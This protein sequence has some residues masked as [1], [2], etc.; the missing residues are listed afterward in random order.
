MFMRDVLYNNN[1]ISCLYGVNLADKYLYESRERKERNNMPVLKHYKKM[2]DVTKALKAIRGEVE[3]KVRIVIIAKPI[4]EVEL[5]SM[6]QVN[7]LG[8]VFVGVNSSSN[9]EQIGTQQIRRSDLALVVISPGEST[10][11]LKRMVDLAA[12]S[13]NKLIIVTGREIN[14]WLEEN[15]AEVFRVSGEDVAFIPISD[16]RAIKSMLVKKII[17]KVSDKEIA[18]A[19]AVPIFR[20]EVASRIIGKTAKQNAVI[21][22]A[23]F[24]LGSDMPLL[25]M[26]QIKMILRLSAIYNEELSAKRLYEILAVVGGG[27]VFRELA[28]QALGVIPVAG[29][30]VKGT[31]SYGGTVAMGQVAKKYFENRIGEMVE[32]LASDRKSITKGRETESLYKS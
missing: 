16:G 32:S 17:D 10:E 26:N 14:D 19:A 24:I 7:A 27:F 25:T 1:Y 28:K 2:R 22:V 21:S 20:E 18:L 15:L 12:L 9:G 8:K 29:W 13:R 6:L 11:D 23:F 30:A 5:I 31:I 4:V 3:K